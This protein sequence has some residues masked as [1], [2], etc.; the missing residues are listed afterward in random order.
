M[1][2]FYVLGSVGWELRLVIIRSGRREIFDSPTWNYLGLNTISSK[3]SVLKS[4]IELDLRTLDY[5]IFL[6]KFEFIFEL[7]MLILSVNTNLCIH[8]CIFFNK[9]GKIIF[10]YFYVR[11]KKRTKVKIKKNWNPILLIVVI[12]KVEDR[13]TFLYIWYSSYADTGSYPYPAFSFTF[14]NVHYPWTFSLAI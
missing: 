6:V 4:A 1:E 3:G 14:Q 8:W 11:V 5:F 10:I 7:S 2:G 9:I 12:K 13:V